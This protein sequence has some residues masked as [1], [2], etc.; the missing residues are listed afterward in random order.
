MSPRTSTADHLKHGSLI[1]SVF[2]AELREVNTVDHRSIWGDDG[3]GLLFT[4]PHGL[5]VGIGSSLPEVRM[6]LS[7]RKAICTRISTLCGAVLHI[8]RLRALKQML[9]ANASRVIAMMQN[10][11]LRM[12]RA[13]DLLG[14]SLS[15]WAIAGAIDGSGPIPA[16]IRLVDAR[17]INHAP[18]ICRRPSIFNYA[19]V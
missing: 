10:V 16:F 9:Q 3:K 14:V 8:V 1:E 18:T 2:P 5:F 11:E 15:M 13:V 17:P 12:H 6:G 19:V 4:L 7:L